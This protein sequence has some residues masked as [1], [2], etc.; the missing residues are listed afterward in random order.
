VITLPLNCPVCA[1]PVLRAEGES[2]ARC[3]GGF[4]CSAQRKEALAHFVGRRALDVDG[5]GDK[6]ID[7]LVEIGRVKGPADLWLLSAAE[8]AA[9]ERMGA[10]SAARL[11]AALARARATTLPRFIHALG[12]PDVG[13]STA[14]ALARHF[15]RLDALLAASEAQLLEVPDVGPV[16]AAKI[17]R[18]F[19][20]Q[21]QR[22]EIQRLRDPLHGAGLHWEESA[23]QGAAAPGALAGL[24]IVLTGT[25]AGITREAASDQLA[26]LGAKVASSVSKQTDYLV[27]GEAAGS[28]LSKAQALGVPV[29]DLSGLQELLAGRR[30]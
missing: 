16:I 11:S 4:V 30:P 13:E 21:R 15:G 25:L 8:L 1:S 23:G 24:T 6:L 9:L 7:Q 3:S 10:K 18:Y 12:I 28:K 20:D 14:A 29:L 2:A 27:A 22:A 17:L 26:A 19:A 5:L